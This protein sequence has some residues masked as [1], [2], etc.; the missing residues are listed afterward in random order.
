M[1]A[2]RGVPSHD[3]AEEDAGGAILQQRT[4][5]RSPAT[6][7]DVAAHEPQRAHGP[8]SDRAAE[9]DG[10]EG[11]TGCAAEDRG[12]RARLGSAYGGQ[13]RA[14]PGAEQ[15]E[16]PGRDALLTERP[17]TAPPLRKVVTSAGERGS[18]V[19]SRLRR[20]FEDFEKIARLGAES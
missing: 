8:M 9:G 14:R 6:S 11:R 13:P 18:E 17:C 10:I 16:P 12:W 2:R 4:R 1:S 5:V 3:H 7:C 20:S 19:Q 15:H